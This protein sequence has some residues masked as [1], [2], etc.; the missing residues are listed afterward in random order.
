MRTLSLTGLLLALGV[1]TAFASPPDVTWSSCDP[2]LVGNSSGQDRGNAFTI[3]ARWAG[4]A[5]YLRSV[6]YTLQFISP[7]AA[8]PYADDEPGMVVDCAQYAISQTNATGQ[9]VFHARFG[10]F[11][12]LYGVRVRID[13][14][15][16]RTIPV[17]STDMDG[18]G[19]TDLRDVEAFRE[20]FVH[21]TSAPETDFNHDGVTN[22]YDFAI[23]RDE[24]VAGVKGTVC[25]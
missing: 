10:G 4:G 2:I 3:Y 5:P 24:F 20:R 12:N 15:L 14:L 22:G 19:A 18:N 8:R 7:A 13:G 1:A 23:L 6:I 11:D 9:A 17:R 25:P 21:D 16:L